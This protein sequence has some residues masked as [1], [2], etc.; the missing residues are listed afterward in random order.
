MAKLIEVIVA[1]THKGE[2]GYKGTIPW[3]LEGDL[4]RFKERT[5]GNIVLMGRKTV[6]SLPGPLLGRTLIVVSKSISDRIG[7]DGPSEED[8]AFIT[9]YQISDVVD[10]LQSGIEL[11]QSTDFY[12]DQQSIFIAGGT[13]IY[14]EAIPLADV[15]H[16]TGV[17]PNGD[18]EYDAVIPNFADLIKEHFNVG[19]L[20]FVPGP[21]EYNQHHTYTRYNRAIVSEM[22]DL[23]EDGNVIGLA[24]AWPIPM[25]KV[26]TNSGHPVFVKPSFVHVQVDPKATREEVMAVIQAIDNPTNLPFK[27][28]PEP[29]WFDDLFDK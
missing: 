29:A 10:S 23:K 22:R 25:I 18:V 12:P 26:I 16:L 3:K 13:G 7:D 24:R 27:L 21:L 6:E 20:G 15:L 8:D 14:E 5:M 17:F 9:K 19:H 1:A 4:K 28:F 11:A 2:I